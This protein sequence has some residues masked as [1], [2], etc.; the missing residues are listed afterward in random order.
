V[1]VAG[2]LRLLG[3]VVAARAGRGAVGRGPARLIRELRSP[4]PKQR[5]PG[6]C[7]PVAGRMPEATAADKIRVES[8]HAAPLADRQP[9]H[10]WLVPDLPAPWPRATRSSSAHFAIERRV[11]L[12]HDAVRYPTPAA[13]A[14][15]AGSVHSPGEQLTRDGIAPFN[16]RCDMAGTLSVGAG[17]ARGHRVRRRNGQLHDECRHAKDVLV[18]V[19]DQRLLPSVSPNTLRNSVARS[20]LMAFVSSSDSRRDGSR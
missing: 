1:Q 15:A 11:A 12:G 17:A 13:H 16:A 6:R 20:A 14:R 5:A 9:T 10:E 19:L 3:T 4:I 8:R 2:R 18:V 7:N